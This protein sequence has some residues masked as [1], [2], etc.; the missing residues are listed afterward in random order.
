MPDLS[1]SPPKTDRRQATRPGRCGSPRP[2]LGDGAD[3]DTQLAIVYQASGRGLICI[4]CT[5]LPLRVPVT[6]T[7]DSHSGF[8][9]S[10]IIPGGTTTFTRTLPSVTISISPDC[11]P[12]FLV[13]F[14]ISSS[15]RSS[16]TSGSGLDF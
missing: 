7:S 12:D 13:A 3:H 4:R 11:V 2:A 10:L 1:A 15:P 8:T 14:A 9:I 16:T 6:S 5:F